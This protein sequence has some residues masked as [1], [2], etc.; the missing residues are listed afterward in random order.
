MLGPKPTSFYDSKLKHGFGYKNPY[1]LKKAIYVNP[2]LY[3]ALYLLSFDVRADVCDIEEIIENVTKSQLKIKQKLEDPIAIE[4]K[5][6]FLPITYGKM[7]YLYETFVPQLELSLEQK[8]F[9]KASTS[10][11][12][13]VNTNASSSSSPPLKMPK[14]SEILKYFQNL[15]NEI[16][17]LHALL[18]AKTAL[19]RVAFVDLE[20]LV[21]R[22]FC[23]NEVEP[24]LDYLHV[25]FKVIQKEFPEDVQVMMNVFE[26]MKSELDETLKQNVLLKDRLL[27]AT[28]IHDVEKYVLM[29]SKT[30]N[31]DLNVE[32]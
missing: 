9:S 2:K 4:K 11:R 7:N 32:I 14:P 29:H 3:D 19:R 25:I 6:N 30:K 31:D 16:S 18:D 24:I 26:S 15:E 12:T 17:K 10:N 21:L 23:Y 13:P 28:L 27:E 5:V 22:N 20:D 8:K 1:T